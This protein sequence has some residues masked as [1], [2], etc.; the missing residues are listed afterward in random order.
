MRR[1]ALFIATCFILGLFAASALR[2]NLPFG[3][4]LWLHAGII[5]IAACALRFRPHGTI[6]VQSLVGLAI[7]STGFVRFRCEIQIGQGDLG[8][9]GH[10]EQEA[11]FRGIVTNEPYVRNGSIRAKVQIEDKTFGGVTSKIQGNIL[12]RVRGDRKDIRYGDRVAFSGVLRAPRPPRNP[13]DFDGKAYAEVQGISGTVFLKRSGDLRILERDAGNPFWSQ[14]VLPVRH[15]AR[16]AI[17]RDLTGNPSALLKGVLLGDRQAFP[18]RLLD[19]FAATGLTHTLAV[20]GFNVGIVALV[21]FT[22]L[23]SL[24]LGRLPTAMGVIPLLILYAFVTGLSPSVVRATLMACILI[25]G[26]VLE[27]DVDVLNTL[28]LSAVILLWIW[29]M[30]VFDP[31]FQLSFVATLSLIVLTR[32]ILSLIQD[33]PGSRPKPWKTWLAMP[34]AASV[35]AQVGS[36][37]VVAYHFQ[38]VSLISFLANL[39]TA[40]LVSAATVLGVLTALV[41]TILPILSTLINGANYLILKTMLASVHFFAQIPHAAVTVF[42]PSPTVLCI[43]YL[44]VGLML[45]GIRKSRCGKPLLFSLLL[46]SNGLAWSRSFDPERGLEIVFL[47][48][49]QGDSAFIR[50]PDGKTMLIDGGIRTRWFDVGGRIILPFLRKQGIRHLDVVVATHPDLDHIGGLLEILKEIKVHHYLDSGQSS[51][52]WAATRIREVVAENQ[53]PH[54]TLAAGDS[55]IG[56]GKVSAL[57]LHPGTEFVSRDPS[58]KSPLGPNNGSVVLRFGYKGTVFLLTGDIERSA[59]S[60]LIRWGSRIKANILKVPHHGSRTSSTLS[61]LSEVSPSIAVVSVGGKNRFGHPAPDV[62]ARYEADGVR[63]FRTDQQGAIVMRVDG[64]GLQIRT[65]LP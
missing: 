6:V 55:L 58:H 1:P 41:G 35:A 34:V 21:G 64:D 27:R 47:D 16:S 60:W 44:A 43:Y 56:L 61:F 3:A 19:D 50:F 42:A 23:R 26:T 11:G 13:G 65:W 49:G 33:P 9:R 59:E 20:S 51:A 12:L 25:I 2:S 5:G 46:L 15:A 37:P 48:V 57:V 39:P 17:E 22:L 45:P 31:G 40:P 10:F 14:I 53:I 36:I 30:S 18:Q 52:T 54:Q 7:L 38:T 4:V 28:G 63:V 32:P 29:P 8:R 24:S 62:L